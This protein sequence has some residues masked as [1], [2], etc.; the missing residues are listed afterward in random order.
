L[1]KTRRYKLDARAILN[2]IEANRPLLGY[3]ETM[4]LIRLWLGEIDYAL[5]ILLLHVSS[6]Y[7][8]IAHQSSAS[9]PKGGDTFH[10]LDG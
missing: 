7:S 1:G 3:R 9:Q 4:D 10:P 6:L 8:R 2:A 5:K